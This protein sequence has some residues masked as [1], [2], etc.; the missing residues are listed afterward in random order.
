VKPAGTGPAASP[1]TAGG[2][3]NLAVDDALREELITAWIKGNSLDRS[4]VASTTP[5]SVY[6]AYQPRSATYW[7]MA[8]FDPSASAQAK[9]KKLNGNTGDP[10]ISF[11]DGPWIFTRSDGGSWQLKGDTGGEVCPSVLPADIVAVWNLHSD[12]PC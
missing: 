3:R 12:S 8:N 11:Q 7:A 4:D 10:L 1:S 6:Y 9:G 2:V 5:G